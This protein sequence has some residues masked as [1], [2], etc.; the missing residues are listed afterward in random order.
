M[1]SLQHIIVK[2]ISTENQERIWKAV[3][4]KNQIK[5]TSKSIK[6]KVDFSAETLKARRACGKLF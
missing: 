3:R 5:C 1:T 4:E 2:T 6:I